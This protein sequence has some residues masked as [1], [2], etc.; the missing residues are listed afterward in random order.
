MLLCMQFM[1]RGWKGFKLSKLQLHKKAT[2]SHILIFF[3]LW[4]IS[5]GKTMKLI[6]HKRVTNLLHFLQLSVIFFGPLIFSPTRKWVGWPSF[7]RQIHIYDL[8]M[9]FILFIP[10]LPQCRSTSRPLYQLYRWQ[11]WTT[12]GF[13]LIFVN[14]VVIKSWC[15]L[16]V[17]LQ[18][19][20]P[21]TPIHIQVYSLKSTETLK[22]A[23]SK[24]GC[25]VVF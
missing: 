10:L 22:K 17:D 18:S 4:Y 23:G 2:K 11:L 7:F 16:P 9:V 1:G 6:Y 5:M 20:P 8:L 13:K 3:L 15:K 19:N 24:L 14:S 25:R 21:S 12:Y